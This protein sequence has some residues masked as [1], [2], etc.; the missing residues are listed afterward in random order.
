MIHSR[1][2][3]IILVIVV[4]IALILVCAIFRRR[5]N[6]RKYRLEQSNNAKSNGAI[7]LP[8]VEETSVSATAVSF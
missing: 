3:W 4:I 8:G 5:R 7:P 1:W 2:L 6:A